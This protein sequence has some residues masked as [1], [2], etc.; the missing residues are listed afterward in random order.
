MA[1]GSKKLKTID[2]NEML[3]LRA[4]LTTSQTNSHS[5]SQNARRS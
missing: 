5:A 1:L 4:Y 3:V 2:V